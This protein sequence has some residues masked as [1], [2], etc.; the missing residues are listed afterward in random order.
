MNDNLIWRDSSF[1]S[2]QNEYQEW[3]GYQSVFFPQFGNGFPTPVYPPSVPPAGNPI[4]TQPCVSTA[5]IQN[6]ATIHG[7]RRRRRRFQGLDEASE[8]EAKK[9]LQR[10]LDQ[11]RTM[12]LNKAYDAIRAVLPHSPDNPKLT[13]LKIIRGAIE[14]IKELLAT[15]QNEDAN[16]GYPQCTCPVHPQYQ[17][18]PVHNPPVSNSWYP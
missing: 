8:K 15:L 13:K 2:V 5:S 18:P 14:Y 7:R 1:R 4:Q 17:L 9:A 3:G 6:S 10:R 12:E 16:N 11:K